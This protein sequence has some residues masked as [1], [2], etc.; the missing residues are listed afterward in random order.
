MGQ[1]KADIDEEPERR[2]K[3]EEPTLTMKLL[4]LGG[5]KKKKTKSNVRLSWQLQP[6]KSENMLNN[7]AEK[8]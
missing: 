3:K 1:L 8:P 6:Q 2:P 7:R 5:E 4:G